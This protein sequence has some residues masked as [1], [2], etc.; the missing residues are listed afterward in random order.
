MKDLFEEFGNSITP[1]W[2]QRA[3]A[4]AAAKEARRAATPPII[5]RGLEKEQEEKSKQLKRY[6]LWKAQVREGM[7]RGDYGIE[8]VELLKHLR[9]PSQTENLVSYIL[10]AK[11]LMRCSLDTRETLLGYIDDALVRH[12]IR[13]GYPPFDDPLPEWMGGGPPNAFLIIRKHLTGV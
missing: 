12:A 6:R 5:K 11:W 4:K 2:K 10:S 8:I 3:E 7:S 1:K 13:N 9:H